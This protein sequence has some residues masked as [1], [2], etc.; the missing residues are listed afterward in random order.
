MIVFSTFGISARPFTNLLN[1]SLSLNFA[2]SPLPYPQSP[3]VYSSYRRKA[4]EFTF[5]CLSE[6]LGHQETENEPLFLY[7]DFNFRLDFS[8]VVKVHDK[9]QVKYIF[10]TQALITC[11]Q[12]SY[13]G[14]SAH[15]MYI[16]EGR[17]LHFSSPLLP[18]LHPPSPCFIPLGGTYT[19][20]VQHI[21]TA[22]HH[23]RFVNTE[24]GSINRIEYR[25]EDSS[26]NTVSYVGV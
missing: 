24:N 16:R 13:E 22:N 18:P 10:Y 19:H 2:T 15:C 8:A 1:S 26:D 17:F 11:K 3:S 25:T 21:L 6:T 14:V 12:Y 4:L 20:P 9:C 23:T 7:G 5:S